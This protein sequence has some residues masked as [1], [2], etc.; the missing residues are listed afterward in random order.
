MIRQLVS[1]KPRCPGQQQP[2]AEGSFLRLA[3]EAIFVRCLPRRIKCD[4]NDNM[5]VLCS[6][7]GAQGVPQGVA[8]RPGRRGHSGGRLRG[9]NWRAEGV[10]GLHGGAL[11][12]RRAGHLGHRL[13]RAQGV[14]AAQGNSSVFFSFYAVRYPE[15]EYFENFRGCFLGI[16]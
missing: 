11:P 7:D 6:A 5:C 13:H 9:Y 2:A 15:I 8:Q 14:R 12:G 3:E 4:D 16:W 10:E 1:S